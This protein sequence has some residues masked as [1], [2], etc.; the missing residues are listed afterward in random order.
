M[1]MGT[2]GQERM[3]WQTQG[4]DPNQGYKKQLEQGAHVPS[5]GDLGLRSTGKQGVCQGWH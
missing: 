3:L 1:S 4:G 2:K 5:Q